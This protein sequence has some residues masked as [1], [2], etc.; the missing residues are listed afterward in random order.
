VYTT[1]AGGELG[2]K[3]TCTGVDVRGAVEVSITA[4]LGGVGLDA[5][6]G[7]A[8][9]LHVRNSSLVEV[10]GAVRVDSTGLGLELTI[11]LPKKYFHQFSQTI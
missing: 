1:E 6:D 10:G 4:C 11:A 2:T 5:V 3:C 9:K 7:L 8:V